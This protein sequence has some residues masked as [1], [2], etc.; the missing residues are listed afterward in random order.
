[1][2]SI[3][4]AVKLRRYQLAIGDVFGTNIFNVLLIFLADA[5]YRG[6]P[7]LGQAGQFE[8][9]GA[10]L[11]VLMTGAF[12]VGLLER[13]DRAI[14]RIGYDALAAILLFAGGLALLAR[15]MD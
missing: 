11:A 13:R 8:A 5:I 14:L 6:E 3:V 15:A 10:T 12:V 4:A 1:M 9:I 2:S 7:V